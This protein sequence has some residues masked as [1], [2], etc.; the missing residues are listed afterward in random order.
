M[1]YKVINRQNQVQFSTTNKRVAY[2]KCREINGKKVNG[3]KPY[4]VQREGFVASP[5]SKKRK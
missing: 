1:I 5:G 2:R 4:I 3:N